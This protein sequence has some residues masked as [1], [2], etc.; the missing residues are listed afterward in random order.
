MMP[1]GAA[2]LA[3]GIRVYNN[4]LVLDPRT[5][6]YVSDSLSQSR[7][8]MTIV[9]VGTLATAGGGA[10][11]AVSTLTGGTRLH[12][13]DDQHRRTAGWLALASVPVWWS[14][15]GTDLGS[16]LGPVP[17]LLGVGGLVAGEG[18][19]FA[20]N[21]RAA[22]SLGALPPRRDWFSSLQLTPTPSGLQVAGQF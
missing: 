2:M 19:Q 12:R 14:F 7:L 18:I 4:S 9:V 17:V 22:R 15:A 13:I 10:T 3:G 16:A 5:G 8:G 11:V 21:A 6:R 20:Q 1:T